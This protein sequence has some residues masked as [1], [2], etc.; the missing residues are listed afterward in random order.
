MR[1]AFFVE[2]NGFQFWVF[3]DHN[4]CGILHTV[5]RKIY[6]EPLQELKK[7]MSKNRGVYDYTRLRTV[8]CVKIM[9]N[10]TVIPEL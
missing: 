9:V 5:K 10:L 8:K 7:V 1:T 2:I 3:V 6:G 4:C